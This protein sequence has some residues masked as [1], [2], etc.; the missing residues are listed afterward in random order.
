MLE[1]LVKI[2]RTGFEDSTSLSQGG[3]AQR[4]QLV[5]AMQGAD[6]TDFEYIAFIV[7][8]YASAS[9]DSLRELTLPLVLTSTLLLP[10]TTQLF[11]FV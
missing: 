6:F 2:P 3:V 11:L 9:A 10:K 7:D 1:E 8:E 4:L 5:V